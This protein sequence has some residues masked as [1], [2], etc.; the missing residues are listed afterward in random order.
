MEGVSSCSKLSSRRKPAEIEAL[1]DDVLLNIF[2]QASSVN[3]YHVL[4]AL[5]PLV[6]KRWRSAIYGA[7]G[8]Y[9]FRRIVLDYS[10]ERSFAKCESRAT[11]RPSL[12]RV[13]RW[14]HKN[15]GNGNITYPCE[16]QAVHAER[17]KGTGFREDLATLLA[18]LGEK[19]HRLS[20]DGK[21][22]LLDEFR[23]CFL[24]AVPNL[25]Q[26]DLDSIAHKIKQKDFEKGV[27][28]LRHL[29]EF[30]ISVWEDGA[31]LT[32]FPTALCSLP[33]LTRLSFEC[34]DL[35]HLPRAVSQ[36][37]KLAHFSVR[38]GSIDHAEEGHLPSVLGC[39]PALET[40][41]L[42]RC[43]RV[44]EGEGGPPLDY[45]HWRGMTNLTHLTLSGNL[46]CPQEKLP[47]EVGFLKG[48]REL[49][50]TYFA[51]VE[52]Q[53]HLSALTRLQS[54][55]I[56]HSNM[57]RLPG[58]IG[59]LPNLLKLDL[60]D[61]ALA[62]WSS[63]GFT[64]LQSLDILACE[65]AEV[66]NSISQLTCLTSLILDEV[67]LAK[68]SSKISC[69]KNL[70]HLD[71]DCTWFPKFPCALRALRAP[72][73]QSVCLEGI[74]RWG[75]RRKEEKIVSFSGGDQCETADRRP[76][77]VEDLAWLPHH[78]CL[79]T[80]SITAPEEDDDEKALQSFRKKLNRVYGHDVLRIMY[81]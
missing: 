41:V 44:V 3:G 75:N 39:L 27:A 37:T 59:A 43:L 4:R 29:E 38:D 10:R 49:H 11:R 57:T 55:R 80:V 28:C 62:A 25:R 51:E 53:L 60:E 61:V 74:S 30:H 52:N 72:K 26:L 8:V 50:L 23:F 34:Q 21:T 20:V 5:I 46:E 76:L 36:L 58:W 16:F 71:L 2:E 45:W 66:T 48:L 65:V 19:L 77:K 18:V 6:C 13:A 14:I 78:P 12:C 64:A 47:P 40:L 32:S 24:W 54:I 68:L 70:R 15:V 7:K 63:A 81:R 73:L 56:D 22:G 67:P 35:G 33:H 42:V 79:Q 69:L 31:G 17:V 9:L 1:S